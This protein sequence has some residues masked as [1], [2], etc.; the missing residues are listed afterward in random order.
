[1]FFIERYGLLKSEYIIIVSWKLILN[2]FWLPQRDGPRG[3]TYITFIYKYIFYISDLVDLLHT[4]IY[5][6]RLVKQRKPTRQSFTLT[7]ETL[8]GHSHFTNKYSLYKISFQQNE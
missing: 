1:M 5:L 6:D 8:T 4:F 3:Y 2:F 7:F